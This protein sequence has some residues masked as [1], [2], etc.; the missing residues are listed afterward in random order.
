MQNTASADPIHQPPDICFPSDHSPQSFET[1]ETPLQNPNTVFHSDADVAH[2]SIEHRLILSQ[3]TVRSPLEGR[4]NSEVWIISRVGQEVFISSEKSV[5]LACQV[6]VV[7]DTSVMRAARPTRI[8]VSDP[9]TVVTD[10][11]SSNAVPVLSAEVVLSIQ[12]GLVLQ[13]KKY[14]VDEAQTRG[15]TTLHLYPT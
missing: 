14:A 6:A 4:D 8:D 2:Q 11:Q 7:E 12:E 9:L 1:L 15:K 3:T 13:N 5:W 10:D